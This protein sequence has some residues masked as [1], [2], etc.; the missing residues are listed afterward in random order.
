MQ[1]QTL[2]LVKYLT[3]FVASYIITKMTINDNNV[4]PQILIACLLITVL[5]SI[6]DM[7][8][9]SVVIEKTN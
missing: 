6:I 1:S 9:P 8:Y 4:N 3:F 7:V 5:Y 2:K